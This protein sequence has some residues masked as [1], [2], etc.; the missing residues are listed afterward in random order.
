LLKS[1]LFS[2]WISKA[3]GKL[4]ARD[5]LGETGFGQSLEV[6]STKSSE[7]SAPAQGLVGLYGTP[8]L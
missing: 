6:G 3:G 4:M 2:K 5:L 7:T 1:L 8:N